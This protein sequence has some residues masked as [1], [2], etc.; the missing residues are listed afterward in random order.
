MK[1]D[2]ELE[3]FPARHIDEIDP[4]P[5]EARWLVEQ[6]VLALACAIIGGA[7]RAWKTWLAAELAMAVATG[8]KALGQFL[9]L[10]LKVVG[11]ILTIPGKVAS[12][13]GSILGK[14]T[15]LASTFLAKIGSLVGS[16]VGFFLSIPGK[17]AGIGAE[18]VKG[19][20]RGMASLPG[21]LLD[22]VANAF[23]S[24]RI[25]I[26]PFH[27]SSS[28]VQIDLPKIELPSFAVGTPF[29]PRDMPA[30]VHARELLI[31]AAESDAIRAGRAARAPAAPSGPPVALP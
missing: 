20:I 14:V 22:T 5:P 17:V 19:I 31:P 28:G 10:H 9:D 27:I 3:P 4:T 25:D 7:P 11:F 18:I 29:V 26:G 30:L 13:V 23:R 21:Q 16:I 6:L 15:T 8:G 2:S 12:W 24:L 1:R